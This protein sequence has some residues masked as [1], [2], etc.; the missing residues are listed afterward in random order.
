MYHTLSGHRVR[1]IYI[2][3]KFMYV[4]FVL[5]SYPRFHFQGKRCA[6]PNS[7]TNVDSGQCLSCYR[8]YSKHKIKTLFI[9][10]DYLT[11]DQ[12][13]VSLDRWTKKYNLEK[14]SL[15]TYFP[16]S[17]GSFIGY[18][19]FN[20]RVSIVIWIKWICLE[21]TIDGLAKF[22]GIDTKLF[23]SVDRDRYSDGI[24]SCVKWNFARLLSTHFYSC[25]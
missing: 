7:K 13:T 23:W 16:Y 18:I 5:C 8:C 21:I 3:Q 20:G 22:R 15:L 6:P 19:V 11:T 25:L 12:I 14:R 4:Y 24:L 10:P 2:T 1:Q 17:I 9:S